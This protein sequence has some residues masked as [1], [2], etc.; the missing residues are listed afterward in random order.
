M[1]AKKFDSVKMMRD[2]R[3]RLSRRYSADPSAE[4][5]DLKRIRAKYKMTAR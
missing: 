4:E 2:I 5:K 3:D 1:K